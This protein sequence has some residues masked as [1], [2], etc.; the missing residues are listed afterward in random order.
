MVGYVPQFTTVI[1]NWITVAVDTHTKYG[2]RHSPHL[3]SFRCR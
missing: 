1:D 3:A 2:S